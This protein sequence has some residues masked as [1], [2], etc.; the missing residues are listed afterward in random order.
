MKDF[1]NLLKLPE[2]IRLEK[3]WCLWGKN[4]KTG[5]DKCPYYY[6]KSEKIVFAVVQDKIEGNPFMSLNN[7]IKLYNECISKKIKTYNCKLEGVGYYFHND[8]K[9]S[10]IDVDNVFRS[11]GE[12]RDLFKD[13]VEDVIKNKS[14]IG[15]SRSGK[16]FHIPVLKTGLNLS[17]FGMKLED[18]AK[19]DLSKLEGNLTLLDKFRNYT[20]YLNDFEYGEGEH[21]PGIDYLTS[22][23]FVALTGNSYTDDVDINFTENDF[24]PFHDIYFGIKKYQKGNLEG[25]GHR[26]NSTQ[27]DNS[28]FA[29]IRSKVT[30][31]DV[32]SKY[33]DSSILDSRKKSKCPLHNGSQPSFKLLNDDRY[34]CYSDGCSGGIPNENGSGVTGDLFDFTQ[35]IL[36]L[37]NKFETLE[38]LKADFNI[39]DSPFTVYEDKES[40]QTKQLREDSS[41]TNSDNNNIISKDIYN[42][43]VL[44]N[45]KIIHVFDSIHKIGEYKQFSLALLSKSDIANFLELI[46]SNKDYKFVLCCNSQLNEDLQNILS[47]MGYISNKVENLEDETAVRNKTIAQTEINEL[48]KD[49]FQTNYDYYVN[50]F[51]KVIEQNKN[52]K[53]IS[54]GFRFL[55]TS[56]NGG[57]N[58]GLY[59]LGGASSLGKTTL[60]YQMAFNASSLGHKVLFFSLEQSREELLSKN[61]SMATFSLDESTEKN[62]SL[63]GYQVSKNHNFTVI[64]KAFDFLVDSARNLTIVEGN[65]NMNV[66]KVKEYIEKFMKYYKTKPLVIIDYLQIIPS[67]D[68]RMSDKQKID[69]NV[70]RLKQINRDLKIPILVLSSLNRDAYSNPIA[71]E[72]FKESGGIEYTADAV[73]GIQYEGVEELIGEKSIIKKRE[74]LKAMSAE[75]PRK[76][77]LVNLK[78]R[79]GEQVFDCSFRYYP[80][81]NIF[82][83]SSGFD[84]FNVDAEED[85]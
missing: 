75:Y 34:V 84:R 20:S 67:L 79:H 47:E 80:K 14:F 50:E 64:D 83:E 31:A 59:V 25:G 26:D 57:F 52:E 70:T 63:T 21:E 77:K 1:S 33:S 3:S 41:P 81:Y 55:D 71:Y 43:E 74:K 18:V 30:L 42:I 28:T 54:T 65:F 10:F 45:E 16:G 48:D 68:V 2:D 15:V 51:T 58:K 17:K 44:K 76:I 5:S 6:N 7:A 72:S 37:S 22:R 32:V 69:T 11:S 40:S 4:L 36:G 12:L 24:K 38:R 27:R 82:L 62:N 85:L 60:A 49:V 29:L 8:C 53:V 46:K 56:L 66:G 35:H 73:M 13:L 23:K 9:Y 61:L 19:S 39:I 78:Y